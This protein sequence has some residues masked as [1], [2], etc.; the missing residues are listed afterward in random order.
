MKVHVTP[1]TRQRTLNFTGAIWEKVRELDSSFEEFEIR[2]RPMLRNSEQ[3][4]FHRR[5]LTTLIEGSDVIKRSELYSEF[6][7][8]TFSELRQLILMLENFARHIN[9]LKA[10]S[11]NHSWFTGRTTL[12]FDLGN[13]TALLTTLLREFN[14]SEVMRP[15]R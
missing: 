13:E 14:R 7:G 10:N 5:I 11:G 2:V 3:D 1:M 8:I 9:W 4:E 6:G 12:L 15:G